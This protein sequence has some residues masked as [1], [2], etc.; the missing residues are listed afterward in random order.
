MK[1]CN[2]QSTTD[3][4]PSHQTQSTNESSQKSKLLNST[5]IQIMNS[6]KEENKEER[7]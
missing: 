7:K 6:S 2:I 5:N 4:I 3:G 1:L